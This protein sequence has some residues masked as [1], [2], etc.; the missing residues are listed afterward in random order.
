[1]KQYSKDDFIISKTAC[2][3]TVRWK[4]NNRAIVYYRGYDSAKKRA[5]SFIKWL[6]GWLNNPENME[7][8]KGK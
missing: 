4:H 8:L 6:I 2:G 5:N 7:W 3:V 1:M